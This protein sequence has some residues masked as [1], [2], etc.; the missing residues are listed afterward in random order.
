M[1]CKINYG[2]LSTCTWT[3]TAPRVVN[4]RPRSATATWG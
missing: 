4:D 1:P 3:T 2:E